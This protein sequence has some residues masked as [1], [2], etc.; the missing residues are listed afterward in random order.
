VLLWGMGFGL[1]P[2]SVQSHVFEASP[3]QM[4]LTGS[5]FVAIAQASIA[6][7]SLVGG[8][9]VDHIGLVTLMSVGGVLSLATS[10]LV[11]GLMTGASRAA[12]TLAQRP[13]I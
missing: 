4:D 8:L 1:L 13:V 11:I 5:M 2:I 10:L 12:K 7:G 6:A 9:I 3:N